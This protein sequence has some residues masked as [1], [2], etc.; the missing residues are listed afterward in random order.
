MQI[1]QFCERFD[2]RLFRAALFEHWSTLASSAV[3]IM[4]RA[5]PLVSGLHARCRRE[6]LAAPDGGFA[7]GYTAEHDLVLLC[8]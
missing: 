5:G 3:S 6:H 4:V 2:G 8:R 1:G 7:D